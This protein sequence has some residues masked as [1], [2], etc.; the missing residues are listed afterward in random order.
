M[1]TSVIGTSSIDWAQLS[2]PI[3]RGPR[4]S[5]VS[6]KLFYIKKF[7]MTENVQKVSNC[8]NVLSS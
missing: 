5:P 6:G 7:G 4:L 1:S 2:T 8:I 3:T